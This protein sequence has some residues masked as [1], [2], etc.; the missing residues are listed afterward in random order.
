MGFIMFVCGIWEWFRDNNSSLSALTG[1]VAA[2][3]KG[4]AVWVAVLGMRISKRVEE[5]KMRPIMVV[6]IAN[7]SGVYHLIVRNIGLS[8]AFDINVNISPRLEI[9]LSQGI[10]G[11]VPFLKYPI[12]QLEPRA[13]LKCGFIQGYENLKERSRELRFSYDAVYKDS[14]DNVYNEHGKIDLRLIEDAAFRKETS[15]Q[16]VVSELKNIVR[17]LSKIHKR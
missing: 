4:A 2:L 13:E 5:A 3:S 16:D 6:K 8:T 12:P 7:F 11:E 15:L 1:I 10:R 9:D 14:L 17:E